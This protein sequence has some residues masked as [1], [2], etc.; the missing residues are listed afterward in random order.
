[1]KRTA[2]TMRELGKPGM[3]QPGLFERIGEDVVRSTANTLLFVADLSTTLGRGLLPGNWRR[4][5]REEFQLYFFQ[6]GVRAIPAVVVSALLVGLGLVLQVIYWLEVAGQEGSVGDFL[7]LVLVREISPVVTALIVIGRSGSV[8]LH[9]VGHLRVGGQI[10]ML[11]SYGIDPVD[12]IA[13]PRC[14]A[15]ALS[16]FLLTIVFLYAA[17]GSGYIGASIAGLTVISLV[18]FADAVVSGMSLGDHLLLV[19]KPVITGFV[20]GYIAIW[21]GLRVQPSVLGVR[22]VL[23]QAFVYSLLA[24]F[25]IGVAVSAVV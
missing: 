10:R 7:V 12:L 3:E 13:I 8:M 11:E 16:L 19:L 15:T 5:M 25:V 14:F 17:L 1:M 18:E 21:L 24:T 22:R 20:I 23:P 6:V 4:T 2:Q 9:E